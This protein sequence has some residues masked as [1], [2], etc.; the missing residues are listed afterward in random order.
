MSEQQDQLVRDL[1]AG[2]ISSG[3]LQSLQ[4]G[5]K[6]PGRRDK[7]L[8]LEQERVDFKDRILVCLQESVFLVEDDEGRRRNRCRCGQDLGAG[9][10]LWK[11]AAAVIEREGEAPF[12][13]GPR[14]ADPDWMVLR[15]FYCPGCATR[16]DVE[17]VPVGY[18]FIH[19]FEPIVPD[20]G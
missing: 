1:V 20:A 3:D 10:T 13:P 2:R 16:L 15:E 7:V 6:D 9:G 11:E 18:P 14:A 5:R 8:A 17:P 4:R 12:F 19:N